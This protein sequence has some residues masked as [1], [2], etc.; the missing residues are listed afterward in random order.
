[1]QDGAMQDL[2]LSL[3]TQESLSL[4]HALLD[5]WIAERKSPLQARKMWSELEG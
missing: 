4:G 1:M 5:T 3:V 2:Q